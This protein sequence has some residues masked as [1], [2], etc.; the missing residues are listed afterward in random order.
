MY[1]AESA[2]RQAQLQ[3]KTARAQYEVLMLRPRPQAIAEAKTHIDAAQA[4]VDTAKA[5][6][7]NSRSTRRLPA[8]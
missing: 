1:E 2:L 8:S 7:R 4:A 5:R 6:Q 3:A